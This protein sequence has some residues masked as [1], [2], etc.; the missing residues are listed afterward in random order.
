MARKK[1]FSIFQIWVTLLLI[2]SNLVIFFYLSTITSANTELMEKLTLTP[3]NLLINGNYICLITSGFLHKDVYHLAFNMLAILIFGSIVE[4]QF[5]SMKML[6]VYFGALVLS[7][8]F[9]T[10][11]YTFILHKNVALI[12]ASGAIMGLISCAMLASPFKITYEML[13]PIPVMFKS[14]AFFYLDIRSFLK[15][16]TDGISHLAHLAGFLSIGLI[17]YFFNKKDR[18]VFFKGLIINILSFALLAGLYFYFIVNRG[19]A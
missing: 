16:E 18:K 2:F 7:M 12:G 13:L 11:I 6:V 10:I 1:R 9:A 4:K 15:G 5:G 19:H 14:W 3:F 8:F 17:V